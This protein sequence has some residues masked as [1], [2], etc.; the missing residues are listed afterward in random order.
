V[1][2]A[3][4]RDAIGSTSWLFIALAALAWLLL[5]FGHPVYMATVGPYLVFGAV[6]AIRLLR[7]RSERPGS[8]SPWAQTTAESGMVSWLS[9]SLWVLSVVAAFLLPSPWGSEFSSPGETFAWAVLNAKWA[10]AVLS[11]L[12]LALYIWALHVLLE[13]ATSAIAAA[14]KREPPRSKAP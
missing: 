2:P 3:G 8:I 7:R 6:L 13:A 11:G 1:P 12:L 14:R 5:P 9:A 4:F 10:A